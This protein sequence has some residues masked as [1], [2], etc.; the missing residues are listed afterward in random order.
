MIV[1]LFVTIVE[2][3]QW[4]TAEAL[5]SRISMWLPRGYDFDIQEDASLIHGVC[6]LEKEANREGFRFIDKDVLELDPGKRFLQLFKIESEWV[7]EDLVP[8]IKLKYG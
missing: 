6:V 1:C 3:A 8:F 4:Q 2:A 7:Q 5:Q